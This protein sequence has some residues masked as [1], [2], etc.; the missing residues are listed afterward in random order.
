M[1][2][3]ETYFILQIINTFEFRMNKSIVFDVSSML[4]VYG[5]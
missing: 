5:S 4:N 3:W 1:D 2:P